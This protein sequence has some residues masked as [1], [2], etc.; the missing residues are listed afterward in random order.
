MIKSYVVK[1]KYFYIRYLH[2][3]LLRNLDM[4]LP[5]FSTI[6]SPL[7]ARKRQKHSIYSASWK[8]FPATATD[9]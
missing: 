8:D 6:L 4:V 2:Y 5:P 7:K 1:E 3:T 9:Q